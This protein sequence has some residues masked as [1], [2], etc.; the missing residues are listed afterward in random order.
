MLTFQQ[1]GLVLL[2]TVAIASINHSRGANA[3]GER[4]VGTFTLGM[5]RPAGCPSG[6]T[7]NAFTVSCPGIAK[8][9][10][11]MI[12]DQKPVGHTK[13]VVMF[14]SGSEGSKWWSEE[15]TKASAFF[16]SLI[17]DGFELV[18][19]RWARGWLVSP[20]GAQSG[21]ELLASRPATVIKWVHDKMYVPLGLQPSVGKC[22][23][24]VTGNSAGAAQIT[25]AMS[26][27]GI[28]KIVDAAIPTSG[29][30]MAAMSK[31]CLQERGY[32]YV[33]GH[34][35]LIDLSYGF[36]SGGPCAAHDPS[37]TDTWIANSN[38]TGGTKYN[39]PTTRIQIIIGGQDNSLI[40]NH[41][42]DY[43]QVLVRAQQPMLMWQLVPGMSHSIQASTDGLSA[44]LTALTATPAPVSAR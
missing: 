19:V 4:P 24:C 15:G 35:R 28:D 30:P 44:L 38:E 11:G 2:A 20:D 13:G 29:P 3:L 26:S 32:A 1:K 17:N 25:Y 31:G 14:F 41:A 36:R 43:F 37:F 22:G 39:Y 10:T 34:A 7:C 5:P 6:F 21:Q 33:A 8:N 9:E 12:A 18:Q 27:Y 40:L 42:R 23:F 16:Q